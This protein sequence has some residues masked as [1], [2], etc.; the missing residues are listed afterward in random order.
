MKTKQEKES[1][2]TYRRK[3]QAKC[4]L[5]KIGAGNPK[6]PLYATVFLPLAE[7]IENYDLEKRKRESNQDI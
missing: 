5:I 3:L 6:H 1:E 4:D 2:E 7:W